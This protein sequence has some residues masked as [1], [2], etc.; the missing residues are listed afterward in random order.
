MGD[1]LQSVLNPIE[2]LR[3]KLNRGELPC[4][5]PAS[6]VPK[7]TDPGRAAPQP[8]PPVSSPS[9]DESLAPEEP[10][11]PSGRYDFDI[12]EFPLFRFEKPKLFKHS[13]EPMEYRDIITGHEGV[14]VERVWRAYP[15]RHGWGG[16]TTQ[17][18]FY[19]LL[20][21][22]I[23][24]GC[25]GDHIE[26]QSFRSLLM[27][28]GTRHP[29]APDFRRIRRDLDTLAGYSFETKNAF[30]HRERGCYVDMN[31]RLFDN[32]FY[33]KE[34]PDEAVFPFAYVKVNMVLKEIARTRGFFALGF[35]SNV[36]YR[37]KPLE[38][39]LAIYLSKKFLAQERHFR[40]VD[41]LCTAL[42]IEATREDNRRAILKRTA[43]GLLEKGVP[44]L[45]A[46]RIEKSASTGAWI[47]TFER[48]KRPSQESPFPRYAAEELA[49][50]V[51]AQLGRILDVL[52]PDAEKDRLWWARC[53]MIF[54]E[55]GVSR[56]LGQLKDAPN[57]RH[58]GRLLT[59]IFKDLARETGRGLN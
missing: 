28:R 42:P 47:A 34:R 41:D 25:D 23:A 33:L 16:A 4:G 17:D 27:N 20:Q 12:A 51:Q 45:K 1:L 39:R 21:L 44:I 54:G 2:R 15:G 7:T 29:S 30:W 5:V 56:A 19:D 32:V 13:R 52:G 55:P 58:P 53:A 46:F 11:E 31:W 24:Q 9:P 40:V 6:T 3:E 49:P 37:L 50:E 10:S 14:R 22:Y 43:E 57:V 38:K 36:Y 48:A 18:L 8:R 26:F 35:A 59:K